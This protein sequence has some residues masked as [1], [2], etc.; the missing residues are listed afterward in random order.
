MA[1][2]LYKYAFTFCLFCKIGYVWGQFCLFVT[3]SG[4][5]QILKSYRHTLVSRYGDYCE[6]IADQKL[7]HLARV[8]RL[9]SQYTVKPQS[10][11]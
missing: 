4:V 3:T 9:N 2:L 6:P 11:R 10:G 8:S 7:R 1:I 5:Q